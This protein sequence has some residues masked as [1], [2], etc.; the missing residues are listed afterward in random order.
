[1]KV[2]PD[3]RPPDRS[4]AS[5]IDLDAILALDIDQRIALAATIWDSIAAETAPPRLTDADGTELRRRIAEHARDPS[6]AIPFDEALRRLRE[7]YG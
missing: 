5:G 6:S 1:M 3:H 4:K 7:R 2:P